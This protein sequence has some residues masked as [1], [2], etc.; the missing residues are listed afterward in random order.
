MPLRVIRSNPRSHGEKI[1]NAMYEDRDHVL[2][3]ATTGALNRIN[4]RC[5]EFT[6]DQPPGHGLSSD[7]SAITEDRGGGLWT[8]SHGAGLNQFSRSTGLFKTDLLEPDS[9][10]SVSSHIRSRVLID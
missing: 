6:S 3:M 4:R 5:G 9:P 8:G 10:F 1:V 2:W 7:V